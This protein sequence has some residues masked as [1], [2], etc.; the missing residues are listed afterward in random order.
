[1]ENPY[2]SLVILSLDPPDKLFVDLA[3]QSFQDFEIIIAREKGIP[4]AMNNALDR[5]KGTIYVRIDDD[6]SL[7]PMWLERLIEPFSDPLIAGVTGPTFVPKELRGNRD[8]IRWAENPKGLLKWLYDDGEFKP[9]GIRKCGCVS[10]DSNYE[11]RFGPWPFDGYE[12]DHLEGTNWAM[13]T[14][15]IRQVGGFDPKFDG[16]SEWIDDDVVF[17]VKKLGY[18]LAYN[19]NA[20]L[21]HLLGKGGHYGNRFEGFGRLKNWLRFHIRHSKFHPKMV[22]YFMLWAFY[23]V[24]LNFRRGK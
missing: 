14:E 3:N 24:S 6:V 10:Y 11:E 2:V 16:V 4:T 1:M 15:L 8:S 13:R 7:P 9:A 23:F 22:V 19:P 5:A 21:Y 20:F 17:K 12:P 18:S